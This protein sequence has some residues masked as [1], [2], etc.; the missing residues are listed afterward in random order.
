MA[1]LASSGAA[2]A[3]VVGSFGYAATNLVTHPGKDNVGRLSVTSAAPPRPV[4]YVYDEEPASTPDAVAAP[5]PAAPTTPVTYGSVP[6][7]ATQTQS[8][9]L[10][11]PSSPSTTTTTTFAATTSTT[12]HFEHHDDHP[13]STSTTDPHQ[14]DD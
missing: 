5:A 2:L 7:A 8:G 6:V 1:L 14:G 4:E 3:M 9:D 12:A 13:D 10:T 11:A